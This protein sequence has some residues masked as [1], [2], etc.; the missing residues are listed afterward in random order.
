M[1]KPRSY[2]ALKIESM[3]PMDFQVVILSLMFNAS[4]KGKKTQN[5]SFHCVLK[6]LEHSAYAKTKAF[7]LKAKI[8]CFEMGVVMHSS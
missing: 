6:L 4:I 2:N 1:N 7:A 5:P 8:T 3:S